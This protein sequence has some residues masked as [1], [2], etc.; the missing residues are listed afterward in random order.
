[1][2]RFIRRVLVEVR[3]P[4]TKW[5]N[6]SRPPRVQCKGKPCS[7]QRSQVFVHCSSPCLLIQFIVGG[8]L[9]EQFVDMCGACVDAMS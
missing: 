8:T 9:K 4:R 6:L 3:A 2:F 7:A 5:S 1:M